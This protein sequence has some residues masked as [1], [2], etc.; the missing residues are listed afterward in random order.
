MRPELSIRALGVEDAPLLIE[1]RREALESSPLAFA[2]SAA[3]DVALDPEAVRRFLGAPDTQAVYGGFDGD[4]LVGMVGLFRSTKLKQRHKATLWG[5]YVH[6]RCRGAGAAR[7]LLSEAIAR[8]RAW[9]IE[10]LH[11]SVSESATVARQ[12]YESAGFRAWGTECRALQWEGR[13]VAEHH[14]VLVLEAG[15]DP[16]KAARRLASPR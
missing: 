6:P 2:A 11:L 16:N 5:M 1:L 4:A 10:R 12:L 14:L 15:N 8:A 9:S 13:F 7:K 3:D